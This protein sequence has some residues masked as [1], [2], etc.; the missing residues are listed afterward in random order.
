MKTVNRRTKMPFLSA[1]VAMRLRRQSQDKFPVD[2][3]HEKV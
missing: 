2:K 1:S 3:G